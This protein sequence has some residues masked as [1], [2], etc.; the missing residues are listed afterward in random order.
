M[1]GL[2]VLTTT[3]GVSP[4]PFMTTRVASPPRCELF[5]IGAVVLPCFFSL[6]REASRTLK[7]KHSFFVASDRTNEKGLGGSIFNV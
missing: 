7:K 3:I 6:V 5:L 4:P 2:V 1:C